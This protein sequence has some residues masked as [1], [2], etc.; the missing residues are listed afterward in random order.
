MMNSLF[1]K[2]LSSWEVIAA[3]VA[4]IIV[5]PLTFYIASKNTSTI[6]FIGIRNKKKNTKLKQLSKKRNESLEDNDEK[7]K[8]PGKSPNDQDDYSDT[9][10]NQKYELLKKL[11]AGRKS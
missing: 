4:F 11:K 10:E 3:I 8:R 7:Q 2:V 6:E 1:F 9:E 5:L